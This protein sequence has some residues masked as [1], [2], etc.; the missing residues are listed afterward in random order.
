M[1]SMDPESS[2]KVTAVA[3]HVPPNCCRWGRVRCTVPCRMTNSKFDD[4]AAARSELM[5]I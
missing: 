4:S 1:T 3:P 2:T 5:D